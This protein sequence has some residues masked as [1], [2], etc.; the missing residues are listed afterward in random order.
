MKKS[1]NVKELAFKIAPLITLIVL[2]GYLA[3]VSE[4][5]LHFDNL[6]NILRQATTISLIAVG[7]LIVIITAGIDLSVGAVMALSICVMGI[8]LKAGITNPLL[9][10]LI[11]IATGTGM[12]IINGLLL[13]KLHLPHPFISTIGTRN[14]SRGLALFITGA[15]PIIGFPKIIE[16]PGSADISGI[17][18]SFIIVLIVYVCVHLFLNHTV[19][20]REIYSVGGNKE[21]AL[22]SGINVGKVLTFVYGFSGFMCASAGII[23]VGRVGGALPLAGTTADLDAIAAVIIG[24]ASFF[25]GKGTVWGT[26][27]GVLLISVIRNGLNLLSASA[28]LQYVVI[29]LVIV[30]AVFVDVLRTKVEEKAKRMAKA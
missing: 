30:I 7:M 16:V 23:Y 11:C 24:G 4:N 20:G 12:G 19:L 25:G 29:G 1:V 27:I 18:L 6:M 14:I 22:L 3:I 26:L 5:F 9:L 21:A 8:A 13:T 15:A 28:D 10:I 2:S 17:P